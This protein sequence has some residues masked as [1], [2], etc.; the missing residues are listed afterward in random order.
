MNPSSRFTGCIAAEQ[1]RVE[2]LDLVAKQPDGRRS[3][4]D[5]VSVA[6]VARWLTS[7]LLLLISGAPGTGRSRSQP[8]TRTDTRLA[9]R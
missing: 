8:A 5:V 3:T 2:V 1:R 6:P 7:R 9:A 4:S